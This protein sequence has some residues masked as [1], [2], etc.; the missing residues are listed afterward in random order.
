MHR[1]S[2]R[3]VRTHFLTS[4]LGYHCCGPTVRAT[5]FTLPRCLRSTLT[6]RPSWKRSGGLG[7]LGLRNFGGLAGDLD[8]Y[9]CSV[10]CT[11]ATRRHSNCVTC[12]S[13]L[14][15]TG[16]LARVLS[17]A[18]SVVK[19]GVLGVTHRSCRPRNTDIAVLIDRRP[20]SPGLVSGARRPNPLPRAIITRLSGDR[21][22]MRA[23]PR[24]RPRNNLYAF[25]TSVRISAYNI[26]SPLGTLGCLVRRLR[27]SVMAV[28]CHI[29]NFAHS[30]GNVGR[31]VSR[32]VGSVR[33]FVSSSVGTLCSVISMGICRRGVFRAGVLLGRFSLGRC[34]FRAG[35][36]S[37][38]SDRHRR[39][40]T[41]L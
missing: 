30:V 22:Y 26:V 28:S 39:V 16:H 25:H 17:R 7:G 41:T 5:T 31:F 10:Y 40:A 12:V 13:R 29:H 24:D 21:V 11:G 8:F 32:R 27:S 34:V 37:L 20:I 14:C 38:A 23:C 4:N 35:P 6:S 3:V 19:T 36:R 15:G 9:V 2:A 18:Y 1:L 33:G